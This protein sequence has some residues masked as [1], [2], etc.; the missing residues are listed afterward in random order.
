VVIFLQMSLRRG[1]VSG[2]GGLVTLL[3]RPFL[4]TRAMFSSSRSLTVKTVSQSFEGHRVVRRYLVALDLVQVFAF[5]GVVVVLQPTEVVAQLAAPLGDELELALTGDVVTVSS[6]L[7][8]DDG[9]DDCPCEETEN[10][11]D[12]FPPTPRSVAIL[13]TCLWNRA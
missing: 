10:E 7:I 12:H 11:T 2:S 8:T 5:Q 3:D 6:E 9:P 1:F 13:D 4:P